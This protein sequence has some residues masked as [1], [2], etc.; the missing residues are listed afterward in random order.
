MGSGS[1]EGDLFAEMSS[2]KL[3][4]T[5]SKPAMGSGSSEGNSFAEMSSFKPKKTE[6]RPSMQLGGGGEKVTVLDE[7]KERLASSKNGASNGKSI[8]RLRSA[9]GRMLDR[10]PPPKKE[11]S[12]LEAR[13][14]A[15]KRKHAPSIDGTEGEGRKGTSRLPMLLRGAISVVVV[16]QQRRVARRQAG[17]EAASAAVAAAAD[18]ASTPGPLPN[19]DSM[20]P[21]SVVSEVNGEI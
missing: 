4:K 14:A 12:E 6:S 1:S 15:L 9:S 18:S 8:S 3:K 5:E 2:F 11:Q 16:S 21:V 19:T 10:R 13:M 20:K 17:L 7:L